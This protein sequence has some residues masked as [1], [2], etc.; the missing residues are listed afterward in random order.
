MRD[1]DNISTV[2]IIWQGVES[3]SAHNQS[4]SPSD[5]FKVAEVGFI[6]PRD[7]AVFSYNTIFGVTNN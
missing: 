5:F 3:F 1:D 7:S 2:K 6:M 4:M